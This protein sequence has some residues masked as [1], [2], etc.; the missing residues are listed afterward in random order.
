M[1]AEGELFT[2][3]GI[4]QN[5]VALTEFS[6]QKFRGQR[7]QEMLLQSA[8]ERTRTPLRVP[9]APS[10]KLLGLVGVVD[11]ELLFGQSAEILPS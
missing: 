10:Q 11:P 1:G 2:P 9:S 3:L 6:R 7:V 8:F 4:D 5:E